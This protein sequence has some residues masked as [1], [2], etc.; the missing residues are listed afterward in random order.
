LRLE[1][2]MS[3]EDG[4]DVVG[5]TKAALRTE[6]RNGRLRPTIVAGKYFITA[7]ALMEMLELCRAEPRDRAYI[8]G[9]SGPAS[10]SGSFST[11][12]MR[13]AQDAAR[14]TLKKLKEDCGTT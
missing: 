6:I 8:S 3:L 5:L 1:R 12:S 10:N 13:Q 4:A 2:L 9:L 14:L 11:V 7:S